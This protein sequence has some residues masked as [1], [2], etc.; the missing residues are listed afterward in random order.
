VR[1][2]T[3]VLGAKSGQLVINSNDP[4]EQPFNVPLAGAV[5]EQASLPRRF[6]FGTATSPIAA[7][8]LRVSHTT[9][10]GAA[11]GYGWTSGTIQTRDR[12]IGG[13]LNRDLAFSPLATFEV[14][15]AYGVWDVT[16]TLGDAT[17]AHEQMGVLLEGA[18]VDEITT[19]VNEF[20]TRS[21][22]VNV[23]D[24]RLTLTL[25]DLGGVDANVAITALALAPPV[26]EGRF[27]FGTASSPVEPGYTRVEPGTAYS[28]ATG[29]GW[30][31]G[32]RDARDRSTGGDLFRDFVFSPLATFAVDVPPGVWTSR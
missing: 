24:G 6:D 25:D 20:I 5:V 2:D 32:T 11:Q 13:D 21:Y 17:A 12:A 8:W 14:D 28:A 22:R 23:A 3:T 18:G 16:V 9:A 4:D 27:D 7:G 15:V 29:F 10:Y 26:A 1:L 31:S 19:R 30:L